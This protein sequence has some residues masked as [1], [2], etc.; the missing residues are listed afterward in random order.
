MAEMSMSVSHG[1]P[2]GRAHNVAEEYRKGL[3]N[4]DPERA[5]LN[6]VLVDESIEGAYRELFGEALERYNAKQVEKG[7][8]ERGISDYLGKIRS[9]KQEKPSYEMVVQ[10]GNRDTNPATDEAC[11]IGSSAIYRDFLREFEK[12]FPALHVYQAAI[13]MDEAT[14][15]LHVAYIPVSTG[16]K[17]G[18]DTRNSLRGALRAMG[19]ADVRDLNADLHGLLQEVASARGVERLDMGC[20]R[21]RL[22]VRDFKAM[23]E[24]IASEEEYPY[25]NDPRLVELV[26][27]QQEQ[28]DA[29]GDALDGVLVSAQ[30]LVDRE[31]RPWSLGT[32]RELIAEL[33]TASAFARGVRDAAR[34][35]VSRFKAAIDAVPSLWRDYVI[36]PVSGR[37]RASREAYEPPARKGGG[38]SLD[39][40]EAQV[41]PLGEMAEGA[42][43]AA[44]PINPAAQDAPRSS[45]R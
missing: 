36:N 43:R 2:A 29:L 18:L 1:S 39:E 21:A 28:I 45:A 33:G 14:P 10:V 12:R 41:R 24:E 4:A 9:G 22:S 11:R 26:V 31:V 5:H 7:H 3:A 27:E 6:E 15:H 17:R 16:N 40:L 30:A 25:R 37:L 32:L 35:A 13:H 34:G 44:I 20:H 8:P 38:M 42:R 23:Q 19:Y